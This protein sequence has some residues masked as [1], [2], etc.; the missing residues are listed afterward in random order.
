MAESTISSKGQITIPIEVRRRLGLATGSRVRFVPTDSGSYEIVP[1][2]RSITS[3]KG[4][5]P[6]PKM[7]VTLEDMEAAIVDS[8]AGQDN[9]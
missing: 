7:P 8:A 2:Q 1:I 9:R 4:M 5:V 3:L 6:A